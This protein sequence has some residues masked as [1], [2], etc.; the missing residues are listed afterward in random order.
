MQGIKSLKKNLKI[1]ID[2]IE[3]SQQEII[4]AAPFPITQK[5]NN[6]KA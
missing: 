3:N 4:F 6:S 2:E 5:N 1:D